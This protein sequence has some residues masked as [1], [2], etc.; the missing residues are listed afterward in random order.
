MPAKRGGHSGI[1]RGSSTDSAGPSIRRSAYRP[2]KAKT[3]L[4]ESW[5]FLGKRRGVGRALHSL[6]PLRAKGSKQQRRLS[7][8]YSPGDVRYQLG[9]GQRRSAPSHD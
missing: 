8:I 9:Q 5:V 4:G 3:P 7:G 1:E 6:E 2:A